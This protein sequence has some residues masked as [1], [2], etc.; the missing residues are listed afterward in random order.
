MSLCMFD[1]RRVAFV[2]TDDV[3]QSVFSS[4]RF[5]LVADKQTV[6]TI[7]YQITL[8]VALNNIYDSVGIFCRVQ[9]VIS[10]EVY[11]VI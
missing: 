3:N 4:L 8:F 7:Q 2:H 6:R 11:H 10:N 1:H 9:I 5:E